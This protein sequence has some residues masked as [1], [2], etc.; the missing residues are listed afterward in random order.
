MATASPTAR[1]LPT[2][3]DGVIA[4]VLPVHAESDGRPA[5]SRSPSGDDAGGRLGVGASRDKRPGSP[6]WA[7]S[8]ARSEPPCLQSGLQADLATCELLS[9]TRARPAGIDLIWS[10]PT[11]PESPTVGT[12]LSSMYSARY[13]LA[14]K[15][16]DGTITHF[17]HAPDTRLS[18]LV[19][20]DYRD[21][22]NRILPL[23]LLNVR[24]KLDPT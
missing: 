12:R 7:A 11:G 3:Q 24:P 21:A 5:S 6:A 13:I 23:Y 1:R 19:P 10:S 14:S 2:A 18:R 15:Q 22:D 9:R 4:L 20:R 17:G 8:A 16:P